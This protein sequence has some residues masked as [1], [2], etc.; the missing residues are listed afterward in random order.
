[1]IHR[2]L[3]L[4]DSSSVSEEALMEAMKIGKI[5]QSTIICIHPVARHDPL[6]VKAGQDLVARAEGFVK[7]AGLG[8]DF[9]IVE[10]DPGPAV[11]KAASRLDADL[12]V[13]GSLGEE[14]LKRQVVSSAV[15]YVVRKAPCDVLVVKSDRPVF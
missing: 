13:M 5:Y 15:D 2:I 7:S 4:L 3:V 14:G 1:M 11:V 9:R 8:F 12:I 6:Q 10:D